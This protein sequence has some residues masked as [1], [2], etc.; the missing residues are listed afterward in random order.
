MEAR[1]PAAAAR[2]SWRRANDTGRRA[3]GALRSSVVHDGAY[4]HAA[5]KTL[6]DAPS[7]RP[8]EHS[9]VRSRAP[10]F[11]VTDDLPQHEERG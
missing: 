1:R 6:V 3:C 7:I 9:Y 2:S 8:S 5:M 10:W 11:E 4:V